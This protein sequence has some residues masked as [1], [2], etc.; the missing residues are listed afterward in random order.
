VV[1]AEG[2]KP[3]GGGVVTRGEKEIGR[4]VRLGGVSSVVA[5]EIEKR[6]GKET[7]TLVLGHL[8]RGGEPTTFDRVLGLR[9]GTAAVRAVQAG[10]FGQMVA[11]NPPTVNLVPIAEAVAR[12]KCV[13]LDCDTVH[14]ARSLGIGV[15]D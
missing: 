2:A 11:L 5:E 7:R 8:L 14:T 12:M 13:P 1:V 4:E 9:F 6:T 10:K 3:K 15:G